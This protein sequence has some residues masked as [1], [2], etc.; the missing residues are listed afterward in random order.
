M[1]RSHHVPLWKPLLVLAVMVLCLA[2]MY[3]P[4]QRLKPGLDLQ[5]GTTFVYEVNVPEGQDDREVIAR[6]IEVLKKRVDPD[7]VRNLVWRAQAGNRIEIQMALAPAQTRAKR[8]AYLDATHALLA[9][10]ISPRQLRSALSSPP[11]QRDAFLSQLAGDRPAMQQTMAELARATDALE[12][13]RPPYEAAQAELEAAQAALR[14]RDEEADEDARSLLRARVEAARN[15]LVERTRA[16]LA[17]R[18]ARDKAMEAALASNV[19]PEALQYAL[20]QDPQPAK[21]SEGAISPRA[22]ALATLKQAHPARADQIQKVADAYDAYDS[23]RGPLDDPNDLVA[24]MKGAGVLEF[25]IAPAP[26][27]VPDVNS[28][29]EQLARSGPLGGQERDYRWFVIDDIEQFAEGLD[30]QRA[31]RENAAAYFEARGMIGGESGGRF[32]LLLANTKGASLTQADEGWELTAAFRTQDSYGF[33]AV[34]FE[35]NAVGAGLMSQ[36]TGNHQKRPMAILLDGR[37]ISAPSIESRIAG[38]GQIS[39]GRGGFNINELRYLLNTLGAGSLEARVSDEPISI[40]TVGPQFGEDNLRRGLSAGYWSFGLVFAFMVFYYFAW[41]LIANFAMIVNVLIVMGVMATV[42]ATFTLPGIAGLVLTIGMAV[43]AN[44][45]IFERIREELERKADLRTAIRMGFQRAFATIVDSNLTTLITCIVLYYVGGADVKGFAITLGIGVVA[46]IFTGTFVS[47]VISELILQYLK[48]RSM[49]MLPMALPG[50]RR[51]LTPNIDWYAKRWAFMAVSGVLLAV[52]LFAAMSRGADL[53]DIEF[54]AGTQVGFKLAQGKTL[55]IQQVRDRLTQAAAAKNLPELAGDRVTVVTVGQT[56]GTNAGEF[57]IATLVTDAAAVSA[58][59]KDGFADVLNVERP[60]HFAAESA[61]TLGEAPVF[62]LRQAELGANIGMPALNEDVTEYLGGVAVV[63][64]QLTP[65]ASTTDVTERIGRMRLQPSYQQFGFRQFTVVGGELASEQPA[66][67]QA[68]R[69]Y[70]SMVVVSRDASTNYAQNPDTFTE[71]TGLA[72]T[73]WAIIR[74]AMLRDTSLGSVSNF[75]SQVSRTM[76][77]QAIVAIILS[78]L[79]MLIYIWVRFGDL[80][81]GFGAIAALVHDV[82]IALGLLALAGMFADSAFGQALLLDP[83]RIN[84]AVVASALTLIGYSVNDTIVTFDRIRENRGK[85][86]TISPQIINDSINQTLSRTL[87]TAV[88]VFM[89]TLVLFIVGGEGV[90]GFAFI[91]LVGI[92]VGTYSSIAIA[93]PLLLL[94]KKLPAAESQGKLAP[95]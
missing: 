67:P 77:E 90:H 25:R 23:V 18:T 19:Q 61:E 79:A 81:F 62:P 70:R 5:G 28:Y 66:D 4:Q 33:N 27:G 59:I 20:Q 32:Y 49:S 1:E 93:S 87:L 63:L 46:N 7:G 29:R 37:V 86:A 21:R 71:A 56:Q 38:S 58:A 11:E 52:G 74:D 60:I 3:P 9:G 55:S 51:L 53:L 94:G 95:V 50:L 39:G 17:A 41:G 2:A 78:W 31:L 10:N 72:A 14:E 88:T 42:Q 34:G 44:V 45:L 92:V 73:E 47:R 89:S 80:R 48:P 91:M 16:F 65:A 15:T 36:L 40:K 6:T 75:S 35:L 22:A 12:L 84:L 57:S 30:A 82:L 54:R 26:T 69:L 13:T 85:L 83:F 24:L 64:D 68:P 43:D 8:Q 76:Q